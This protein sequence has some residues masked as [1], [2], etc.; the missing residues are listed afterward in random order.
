MLLL[1]PHEEPG[2]AARPR[3]AERAGSGELAATSLTETQAPGSAPCGREGQKETPNVLLWSLGTRGHVYS[4][5]CA[6]IHHTHKFKL[7][8][9]KTEIGVSLRILAGLA[10][11]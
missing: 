8:K 9:R 1:Q 7:K 2:A 6:C 4:H 11:N 3:G 5:V 10:W